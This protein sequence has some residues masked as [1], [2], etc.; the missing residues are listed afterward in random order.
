[1]KLLISCH[2]LCQK[3][4]LLNK[5]SFNHPNVMATQKWGPLFLDKFLSNGGGYFWN[6]DLLIYSVHYSSHSLEKMANTATYSS[7]RTTLFK[8]LWQ[9]YGFDAYFKAS[10]ALSYFQTNFSECFCMYTQWKLKRKCHLSE[11]TGRIKQ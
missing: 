5:H 8:P 6:D 3:R 9:T 1:M 2:T 4:L 7:N 10:R 11:N